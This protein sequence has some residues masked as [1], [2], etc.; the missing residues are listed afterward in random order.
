MGSIVLRK[1]IEIAE[2]INIFYLNE[3][4]KSGLYSVEIE[5]NK[6]HISKKHIIR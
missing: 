5:M 6:N 3:K 2:G 1:E 4:I